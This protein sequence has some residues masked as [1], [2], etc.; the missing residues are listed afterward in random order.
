M[1]KLIFFLSLFVVHHVTANEPIILKEKSEQS[2]HYSIGI[3]L[4]MLSMDDY[5]GSDES[6]VYLLPTPY[7][8]YQ[9][10][11]VLIDRNV[12]E[13]VLFDNKKWHL[14]LD[15]AGSL[16][17]DSEE[18]KARAGMDDLNWVGELGPSVE[19]YFSGDS[20]SPDRTYVDFT[21]RKAVQ[22]DFKSI[23]DVGWTGQ[24]NLKNKYQLKSTFLGG[25]TIVDSAASVLFY[26]DKYAQYF[27]SVS[28]EEINNDREQYDASGG[29]AGA[30]LSL[31]GT[32]RRKSIWV[33]L[34]TRYTYLENASFEDSPLVKSNTNLLLGVVIS[35]IFMEQ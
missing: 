33:G 15:A 22:T 11:V 3:G 31:G 13:G 18:N 20:R 10:D 34:F 14:A 9:S 19:Y 28:P 27:Y 26:S 1:S 5:I 7:L 12:F 21:L 35:Y 4:S 23:S 25:K 30:R 32:W 17:V 29:Y 24:I 6:Q 2:P 16:P 8:Y